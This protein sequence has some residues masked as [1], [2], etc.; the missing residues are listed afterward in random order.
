MNMAKKRQPKQSP[1]QAKVAAQLRGLERRKSRS[2]SQRRRDRRELDMI[3]TV[4]ADELRRLHFAIDPEQ[5]P[6][7]ISVANDF[8]ALL[9]EAEVRRM[10]RLF[11]DQG[12]DVAF[13]VN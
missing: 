3:C 1:A 12:R 7:S 13:K 6:P 5:S 10:V 4:A 8:G 9:P 2:S 11:D